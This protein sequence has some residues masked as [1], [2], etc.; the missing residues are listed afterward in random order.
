MC[1]KLHSPIGSVVYLISNS[2]DPK[3]KVE[4]SI[5]ESA[6]LVVFNNG[7]LYLSKQDL[8]ISILVRQQGSRGKKIGRITDMRR[9]VVTGG[10]WVQGLPEY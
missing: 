5:Y 10:L 6:V 1:L 7:A 8:D 4:I 3:K 9:A 2:P